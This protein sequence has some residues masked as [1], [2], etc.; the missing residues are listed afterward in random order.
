MIFASICAKIS[1]HPFLYLGGLMQTLI[2]GDLHVP[3]TH[4][5]YISFLQKVVDKYK[6]ERIIFGGDIVDSYSWSN[7]PKDADAISSSQE[8]NQAYNQL[9]VI[10]E[11]FP[12]AY[13]LAGN[14]DARILKLGNKSMLLP[15]FFKKFEDIWGLKQWKVVDNLTLNIAGKDIFFFHGD[16]MLGSNACNLAL[17]KYNMRCVF[18]HLHS[19][20]G[21][22]YRKTA[23]DLIWA[24]TV[25]CGVDKDSV[26]M[27]YSQ[28]NQYGH[29]LSCGIIDNH[30][31][32]SIIPMGSI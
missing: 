14:H 17:N 2:P 28:N 16:G 21:V 8:F 11:K 6:I 1:L 25:G 24:M 3:F 10:Q 15:Q 23:N 29:I 7:Y 30:G 22:I 9:Q 26:A 31:I 13:V 20:A 27:R 32:P 5:K 18:A 19:V 12:K 4:P